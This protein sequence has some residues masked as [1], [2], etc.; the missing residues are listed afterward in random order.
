M[1]H[2]A[3]SA[4]MPSPEQAWASCLRAGKP[5]LLEPAT[6]WRALE[7]A[8]AIGATRNTASPLDHGDQAHITAVRL[9]IALQLRLRREGP[10]TLSAIAA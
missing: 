10:G 2:P 7:H 5:E 4:A 3:A 8:V 6:L 1:N 9:Y